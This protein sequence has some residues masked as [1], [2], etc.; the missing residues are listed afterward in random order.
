VR[1][2]VYTDYAYRRVEGEA[3]AERA[4]A[5]FI[6]RLSGSF[7]RLVLIGREDPTSSRARYPVG[8][9]VELLSLPYYRSL[10]E[11]WG[12]LRAF[13]RSAT[14]FWRMLREVDCVW[15]LGPHPYALAFAA[16]AAARRKRVVLGTRQ[17]LSAYM[18]FRHPARRSLQAAGDLL[19]AAWRGLSLLLPVVVVGPDL[20]RRYRRASELLEIAVSLVEEQDLVPPPV[21]LRRSYEGEL[22]ILSVGR[23]DAEKNPLLL[24]DVLARLAE[25]DEP[26]WRLVVCGEGAMHDELGVRLGELGVAKAAELKGYVPFGPKLLDLYRDSHALLHVSWTEGLPQVILEAFAAG[27]PVVATDVGGVGEAVGD[28]VRL[29]PPGDPEGAAAA[30]R[31]IATDRVLRERL[32]RS[33]HDYVAARTVETEVHRL[34]AFLAPSRF[35]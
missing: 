17:D 1:L 10:S 9:G 30:L 35:G 5:L 11:P 3:F 34:A 33:G 7:E 31:A 23:L 29:I 6:A 22:Q 21:A 26:S 2:A 14:R 32:I 13:A 8:V 25:E 16:L 27:L 28:A 15:L 12:V 19:D 4:F 20:A 18:R 24:A